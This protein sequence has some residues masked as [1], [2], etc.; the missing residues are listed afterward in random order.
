MCQGQT[1]AFN[2]LR[3]THNWTNNVAFIVAYTCIPQLKTSKQ[4]Q[5]AQSTAFL[6]A[7]VSQYLADSKS[8]LLL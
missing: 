8:V 5:K 4:K 6:F 1:A 7:F 3:K 2:A